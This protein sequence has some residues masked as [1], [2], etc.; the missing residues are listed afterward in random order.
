MHQLRV[1]VV[2]LGVGEQ[3]AH[4]FAKAGCQLRWLCDLDESRARALAPQ[5]AGART[6]PRYEDL[7]RDPELD[8]ISIASYDD[9]HGEQLLAALGAGKHVFVEKP[10]CYRQSELERIQA[11][12]SAH[13]SRP[14]IGSNLV[15]RSAPLYR[16]LRR[17]IAS[18]A[19][20]RVY[21][22]DADY[23]YG[24]IHKIVDGWRG[25]VKDYSVLLGGAVHMIDLL[26]WLVGERPTRAHALGNRLCTDGTHFAEPDFAAATFEFP[27]GLIARVTANFG[28]VH[29][30]QHVL[31]VFGTD[32][33]IVYDDAGARLHE[34]RDPTRGFVSLEESPLPA[35]KGDLVPA[36]VD[37]IRENADPQASVNEHFDTM[38]VCL[39]AE[40]S[41]RTGRATAVEYV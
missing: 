8:V 32:K 41:L 18:G 37:S 27:S 12:W 23:L 2:G 7:V 3:H 9:H 25:R 39:A 24:R 19:F 6:T 35:S 40:R 34:H 17:E 15:L 10:L 30:H 14:W 26:L 22:F 20:G 31:R 1:G 5:F 16:W 36:F 29:P 28:C 21:A 33:T 38:S 4:A 13:E 11:A